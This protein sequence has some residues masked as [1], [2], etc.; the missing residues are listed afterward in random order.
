MKSGCNFRH[1][2]FRTRQVL[3]NGNR[4]WTVTHLQIT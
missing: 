3:Q 2:R 1:V 4:W